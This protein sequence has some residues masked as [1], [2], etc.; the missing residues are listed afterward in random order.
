MG[1]TLS[2]PSLDILFRYTDFLS[3][4]AD[5]PPWCNIFSKQDTELFEFKHD[6]QAFYMSGPAFKITTMAAHKVFKDQMSESNA[7]ITIGHSEGLESLIN[8]FEIYRDEDNLT[9][10]N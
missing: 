5:F 8:A 10:K 4:T 9:V 3:R 2:T 1:L 7:V 6:L